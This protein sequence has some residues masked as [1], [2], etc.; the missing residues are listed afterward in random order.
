MAEEHVGASAPIVVAGAP[1]TGTTW[2]ASML[3][4]APGVAWINEPD[5]EWP[6]LLALR[7]KVELGRFPALRRED[8]ATPS[9]ERVWQRALAGYRQGRYR[10]A[11]AWKLY[12][13]DRER[14][15][16]DLWRATCDHAHR[17]V[18]PRL[19]FLSAIAAA[20]SVR[21]P[22]DRILVKSVHAPL[23][24]EWIGAR[25]SPR[26]V[27]VV[28][29][30]LNVLASWTELGWGGNGLDTNPTVRERFAG[31]WGMP[32]LP[33]AA[34]PLQRA[35]WE[36]ALFTC[37]LDDALE[38]HPDWLRASHEA[39]CVD[40]TRGFR[41]LHEALGLRWTERADELLAQGDRPGTAFATE[42]VRA[43]QPDRWRTRLS[44]RQLEE[45]RSVL[46]EVDAPWV[47]NVLRESED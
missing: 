45:I 28:R 42:R 37:A 1:R 3:A 40:A 25:F 39:L 36:V 41:A 29:H 15:A 12:R 8:A 20:P 5:N 38:R 14:T 21:V 23:A 47:A 32:S 43:E 31:R 17:R 27:V 9:Y 35:A 11:L 19:R 18:S 10:E 26:V 2:I 24:L 7:S 4:A 6:N 22:A 30:P 44:A 46:R 13:R 16:D 34:T 33:A